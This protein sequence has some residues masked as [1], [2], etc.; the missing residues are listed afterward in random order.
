MKKL[1][2]DSQEIEIEDPNNID[3]END[4]YEEI[5]K[6]FYDKLEDEQSYETVFDSDKFVQ[7][8]STD[9]SECGDKLV[10]LHAKA[11]MKSIKP[12]KKTTNPKRFGT[13]KMLGDFFEKYPVFAG[14][15]A[16]CFLPAEV[17]VE[18]AEVLLNQKIDGTNFIRAKQ[19]IDAQ[20]NT[21]WTREKDTSERQS[22]NKSV[23][24][25]TE[26]LLKRCLDDFV[27]GENFFRVKQPD[28]ESYGDFVLMCLPNNLF[29]SAK[30]NKAKERLLT[31]GFTTDIIAAGFFDNYKEFISAPK[32][33]HYQ[34]AGFLAL[35]LPDVPVSG[36]Q[37][38]KGNNTYQQV[39][40]DY[41]KKG[42]ERPTNINGKPLIR[43]LSDLYNDLTGLLIEKN[44]VKRTI[45][46]F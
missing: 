9:R 25:I 21:N 13:K 46:N 37:V 44:I 43:K 14:L 8:S 20:N 19:I 12:G 2:Y 45:T 41:A 28:V 35:Y 1:F 33:R 5:Y 11:G 22:G 17:A 4:F 34:R 42:I 27:D 38:E 24:A 18:N 30:S 39:I 7:E 26:K 32:M 6:F 31:S 3:F 40:E 15:V 10:K 36:E 29:I 16:N 23:G